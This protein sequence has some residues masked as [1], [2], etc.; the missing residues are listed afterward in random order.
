MVETILCRFAC[1]YLVE[2]V[3]EDFEQLCRY[4]CYEDGDESDEKATF[5][6]SQ[7]KSGASNWSMTPL[8]M[9]VSQRSQYS[10]HVDYEDG[11][12]EKQT[13]IDPGTSIDKFRHN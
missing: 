4:E 5:S 9:S 12:L 11:S 3:C 1:P 7:R 13:Y 2:N 8:R 10:S 6:F